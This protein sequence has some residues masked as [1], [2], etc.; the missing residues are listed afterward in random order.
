MQ[1]P[2]LFRVRLDSIYGERGD[3]I[4]NFIQ[5]SK[6]MPL[7]IIKKQNT[8]DSQNSLHTEDAKPTMIDDELLQEPNTESPS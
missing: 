5:W 4:G 2:L 3:W 7:I 1:K 6:I 8:I